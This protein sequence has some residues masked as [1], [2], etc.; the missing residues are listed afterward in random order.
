L[1][2]CARIDIIAWVFEYFINIRRF[3]FPSILQLLLTRQNQ[4]MDR[5]QLLKAGLLTAGAALIQQPR[6]WAKP[7]FSTDPFQLGVASG[8]PWSDSVVLWTRL[9]PD[10][11]NGGGMPNEDV[12]VRGA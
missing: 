6:L 1:L 3:T 7:Q 2:S 11:L 8:E 4:S 9:A 10:P 12:L 5:R